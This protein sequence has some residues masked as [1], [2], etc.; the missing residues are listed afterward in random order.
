M[1]SPSLFRLISSYQVAYKTSVGL[2]FYLLSNPSDIFS[3]TPKDLHELLRTLESVEAQVWRK[4][5][6]ISHSVMDIDYLLLICDGVQ[7]VGFSSYGV[8]RR[9]SGDPCGVYLSEIMILNVY[10]R[11]G[12]G[13]TSFKIALN[14]IFERED[15]KTEKTPF[16]ILSGNIALFRAMA[17]LNLG[18]VMEAH[19]ITVSDRDIFKTYL[20]RDIE[21]DFE[22]D[23]GLIKA[24]WAS[25]PSIQPDSVW[26]STVA[27]RLGLP[28][29]VEFIRGDAYLRFYLVH[30]DLVK[31]SLIQ[32]LKSPRTGVECIAHF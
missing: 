28:H 8:V 23:Q 24:V 5:Y 29:N 13:K 4:K 20:H 10:H 31:G 14:G 11:L 9:P 2:D 26:T 15:F 22:L 21:F 30:E 19:E 12:L 17:S 1:L 3:N 7:I 25:Q 6:P 16:T 27:K 32:D 18:P